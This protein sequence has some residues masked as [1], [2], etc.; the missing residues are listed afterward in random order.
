MSTRN[1]RPNMKTKEKKC[2][3]KE[4][5]ADRAGHQMKSTASQETM[6]EPTA[7][8]KQWILQ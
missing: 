6:P 2:H 5:E 8:S 3:D 1:C 4:E 7:L